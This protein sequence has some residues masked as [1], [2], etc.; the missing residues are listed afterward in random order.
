MFR[1]SVVL[2]CMI[3]AMA[4][5]YFLGNGFFWAQGV[6]KAYGDARMDVTAQLH[7]INIVVFYA[8]SLLVMK[9]VYQVGE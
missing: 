7:G 4:L 2:G 5:A 1:Y 6:C 8:Y 9:P 3:P